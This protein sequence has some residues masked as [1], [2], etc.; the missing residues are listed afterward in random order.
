MTHLFSLF[1]GVFFSSVLA[2]AVVYISE[3]VKKSSLGIIIGLYLSGNVLGGMWGRVVAGLFSDAYS[4]R[5]AVIVIGSIGLIM[6]GAF[7]MC[8]PKSQK[9]HPKKVQNRQ[10]SYK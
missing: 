4:W 5:M 10:N 6:T 9:F 8:F 1:K 3:E 2:V 7:A